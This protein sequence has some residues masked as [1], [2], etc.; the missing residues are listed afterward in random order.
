MLALEKKRKKMSGTGRGGVSE[1]T[2][3][4]S[5][6]TK[7]YIEQHYASLARDMRERQERKDQLEEDM[8]KREL[9][10]KEKAQMRKELGRKETV[11][12]RTKRQR[13]SEKTFDKIKVIGRGAFGEVWIVRKKD[14]GEILAMKKLKKA[15]MLAKEQVAHV[16]AER[17]ILVAGHSSPW[18][19]KLHYSFQDAKFLYLLMEFLPGGDMMTMLIKYDTFP[20][21]WARFYIAETLLAIDSVHKFGYIHRDLKPDNLLLDR[22][23]HVKLTD[24]G[25]CT[26][27]HPMHSN[28]FYQDLTARAREL[29]LKKIAP[30]DTRAQ[31]Q[32]T[33]DLKTRRMKQKRVLAYSTVGTPDYTAPEVFLQLGYGKEC[34]LWSL[35]C[36]M[37]EMLL[38]YP[39]FISDT[40][41]ETCLKIINWKETFVIPPEPPISPAAAD[42]IRHLI[43]D[44][45]TRYD[46]AEQAMA[47]PWFAGVVW[48]NFRET[49]RA[50]VVPK[51]SSVVDTSNFDEFDPV[52][53]DGEDLPDDDDAAAAGSEHAAAGGGAGAAAAA[54]GGDSAPAPASASASA[55]PGAGANAELPFIGY[56]YRGGFDGV[57]LDAPGSGKPAKRKGVEGLFR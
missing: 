40:S 44:R 13:L 28:A 1:Q 49:H 21:D 55:V 48:E 54:A 2:V 53:S 10:E 22:E 45:S 23:G 46:S 12:M 3:K 9:S 34:D 32:L 15:D 51:L 38:G 5:L 16:R 37:F 6:A 27:F 26:G 41:T 31:M 14:S 43:C 36:I 52:L 17:D 11:Y 56:T 39:P 25:L 57:K 7:M 24:F 8:R 4:K 47:H 33:L 42:L 29:R 19:V 20:E 18:V 35:G 30:E 50:P